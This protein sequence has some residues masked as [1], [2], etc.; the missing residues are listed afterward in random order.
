MDTRQLSGFADKFNQVACACVDRTAVIAINEKEFTGQ[1]EGQISARLGKAQTSAMR[2]A[3]I[4]LNVIG[5]TTSSNIPGMGQTTLD[6]DFNRPVGLSEVVASHEEKFFPAVQTMRLHIL[7]TTDAF[8]G[9]TLRSMAPGELR[10]TNTEDFPPPVGSTYSLGAPVMLEDIANPGV[11]LATL[12]T[13]NTSIV[14]TEFSPKRL[15]TNKG[16]I[17]Y[18]EGDKTSIVSAE[19]GDTAITFENSLSG[20]VTVTLFDEGKRPVGV[21]YHQQHSEKQQTV[22]LANMLW[23]GRAAYYQISVGGLA[24]T[25]LMLI[26]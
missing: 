3:T 12:K 20:P 15:T 25:A 9:K 5:Y 7:V 1:F 24:R 4:P 17:L 26:E 22:R 16:F 21:A 6:F 19:R 2:L 18:A 8:K 11:V 14:S 13:V 10:N 23:R